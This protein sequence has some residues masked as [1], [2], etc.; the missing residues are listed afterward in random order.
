L[1]RCGISKTFLQA[2]ELIN[3]AGQFL[4][5]IQPRI[6]H[7]QGAFEKQNSEGRSQNPEEEER[8][9]V[10]VVSALSFWLLAS[11]F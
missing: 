5:T 9:S 11:G 1:G 2:I 7:A 10:D 4:K 6:R 3:C 8:K